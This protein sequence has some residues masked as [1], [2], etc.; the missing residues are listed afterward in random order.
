MKKRTTDKKYN[1]GG[2]DF[3]LSTLSPSAL[4]PTDPLFKNCLQFYFDPET[5]C[6]IF[7]L[8]QCSVAE[9][10]SVLLEEFLIAALGN[11][12]NK[13]SDAFPFGEFEKVDSFGNCGNLINDKAPTPRRAALRAY[14]V[15]DWCRERLYKYP[16][17]GMVKVS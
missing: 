3:G 14:S 10:E 9:V 11:R 13:S 7:T 8:D 1:F 15:Y 12:D 4:A 6:V 16:E 5:R 2:L 17:L